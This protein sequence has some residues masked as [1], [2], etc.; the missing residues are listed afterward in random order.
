[1]DRKTMKQS[2]HLTQLLLRFAADSRTAVETGLGEALRIG[3]FWLGVEFLLMGLSKIEG[4]SLTK[5]LTVINVDPGEFRA[6]LRGLVTIKDE[7]WQQHQDVQDLGAKA[8]RQLQE[9]H[10]ETL[11]NDFTTG[12]VNH[13]VIT[14]R[15]LDVFNEAARLAGKREISDIH[16]LLAI[17]SSSNTVAVQFLFETLEQA[18]DSSEKW[19]NELKKQIKGQTS[20]RVDDTRQLIATIPSDSVLGEIGRDLS[21]LALDGKLRPAVGESARKAMTKIALVLQQSQSNNPMLLG[22][23]GVG[24]TAIV[25]GLAWRLA[26]DPQVVARMAGRHIIEI[27]ATSLISGTE[28]RG[29]LEERIKKLLAE[30]REQKDD[31]IVFIDEIHTILG[32]G[33]KGGLG[34]ISDALKPALARGEFPCIGATTVSEYRRYIEAD[35]ALA[36]RFTPIWVEEPSVEEAIEIATRVAQEHL[37]PLHGVEYPPEIIAEAVQLSVRYINDEFL[38]GKVIKLLDQAGPR[39]TMGFSLRGPAAPGNKTI[40]GAVTSRVIREIMAERTGIPLANMNQD[41]RSK[42]LTMES[43]LC[44]RVR[45]QDEAVATVTAMVKRARLGL[46]DP[47]RPIGVFLFAGPTGVG[48]TEL[49]LA[50]AEALFDQEDAILRLDM[51]EYMDKYQVTRLIGAPPG[52]VGYEEEGQLTG[53]LRRRPYSVILLD[54]IE[55]AHSDIQYT[56]LQLFDAGRLTDSRGNLADGRNAIFIM[57]TNLGARE[58]IGFLNN[59]NSYEEKLQAAIEK[60]FSA[61]FLNRISRIVYFNPLTEDLLLAIFDKFLA[62]ALSRFAAQGIE[63]EVSDDFKRSLCRKHTDTRRGARPL[64]RAIEDEIVIPLTEKLL[65]GEIKPGQKITLEA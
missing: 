1:M 55:K 10:P 61:E 15:L 13:P 25:E 39:M 40:G 27:S 53:H 59:R 35:P 18:G 8:L 3:Q 21:A 50:L 62:Q 44:E 46:S 20:P 60:H 33:V 26:N 6:I 36:R 22:D 28:Y 34:A 17:L 9:V 63:V 37:S 11:V 64:Q 54:E 14:S 2:P 47:K 19:A 16:L 52:Y 41:D 24:K 42:L 65:T 7:N 58:A 30:V 38:P 48:K 45:G 5:K 12:S 29:A 31:V 49:A 57:T 51:S 4:G 56:F 23:P 32:G 43:R